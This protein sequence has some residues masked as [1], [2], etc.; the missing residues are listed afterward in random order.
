MIIFLC[1]RMLSY[2]NHI[3]FHDLAVID[4]HY[5]T[6]ISNHEEICLSM[7]PQV[8]PLSSASFWLLLC[9]SRVNFALQEGG[10][11]ATNGGPMAAISSGHGSFNG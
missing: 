8:V 1:K 11:L 4:N 3:I 2:A 10:G 9:R 5:V 7:P 6:Y